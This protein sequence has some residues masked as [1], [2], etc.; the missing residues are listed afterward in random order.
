[1][2]IA[3]DP[4]SKYAPRTVRSVSHAV[5]LMRM[6]AAAQGAMTLTLLSRKIGLSK[7]AVY[8]LMNSMLAEGVVTASL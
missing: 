7:P 3:A 1:M 8:K 4:M 6:L 5:E 2:T